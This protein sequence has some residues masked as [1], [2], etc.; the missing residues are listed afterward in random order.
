MIALEKC[1]LARMMEESGEATSMCVYAQ[2]DTQEPPLMRD[3][4]DYWEDPSSFFLIPG[5]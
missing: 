2:I 5:A 1:C 3:L 4:A